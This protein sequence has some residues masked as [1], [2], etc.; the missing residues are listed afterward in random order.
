[1]IYYRTR[2][3][4]QAHNIV[5]SCCV[6]FHVAKSLTDF[7]LCA[8]TPKNTQQPATGYANGRNM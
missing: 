6:R 1:M 4:L 5:G 8:T 2:S 3:L 7:K